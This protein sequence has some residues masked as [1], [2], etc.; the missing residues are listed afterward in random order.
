MAEAI[1]TEEVP[2]RISN[3][4]PGCASRPTSSDP[5]AV[6]SI[7]GTAPSTAQSKPLR[8]GTTWLTGTQV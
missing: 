4:W 8:K 2:P 3:D 5:Y 6:C 7:S 1:P